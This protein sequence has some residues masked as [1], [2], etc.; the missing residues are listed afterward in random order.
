MS[1][2]L[3]LSQKNH[4]LALLVP[5]QTKKTVF[6]PLHN[7]QLVK[8]QPFFLPEVWKWN[9]P[10]EYHPQDWNK[11][12]VSWKLNT[13]SCS[14]CKVDQACQSRLSY[15]EGTELIFFCQCLPFSS[16]C[17]QA[18]GLY[19]QLSFVDNGNICIWFYRIS[20]CLSLRCYGM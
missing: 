16:L 15:L 6:S 1:S 7:F 5:L 18:V 4:Q 11:R 19:N 2:W 8:S 14:G 13:C 17:Q 9:P 12:Y 3:F 10:W 20:V